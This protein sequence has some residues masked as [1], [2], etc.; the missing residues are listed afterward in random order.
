MYV[1]L[2]ERFILD[3][4]VFIHRFLG[5]YDAIQV[6]IV[7]SALSSIHGSNEGLMDAALLCVSTSL[8][9]KSTSLDTVAVLYY[10]QMAERERERFHG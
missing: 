10:V 9:L 8:E 7:P 4:V 5:L 1:Y 3:S 2:M 6:N